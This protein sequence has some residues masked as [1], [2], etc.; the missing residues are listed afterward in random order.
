MPSKNME[1]EFIV[2]HGDTWKYEDL[3]EAVESA[4]TA[5]WMLREW[6][7]RPALISK[8]HVS[9]YHGQR[10]DPS[11]TQLVEDGWS[12]DHCEICW[13][14]LYKSDDPAHGQGYT[15]DGHIWICSEC[16]G[17]FIQE[18]AVSSGDT[19]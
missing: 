13:W 6:K 1:P 8:G 11:K 3:R 5:N 15:T 7:P 10:F 18:R 14:S 19:W 17:L 4:K 2:I 16:H 9:D 12:H